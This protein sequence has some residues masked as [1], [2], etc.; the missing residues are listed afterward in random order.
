M[1]AGQTHR[2]ATSTT[3]R[4]GSGATVTTDRAAV[5]ADC[6]RTRHTPVRLRSSDR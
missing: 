1:A 5:G 6:T 2:E 4:S 3:A